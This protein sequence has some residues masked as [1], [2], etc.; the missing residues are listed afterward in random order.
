MGLLI[1]GFFAAK[2]LVLR[3]PLDLAPGPGYVQSPLSFKLY[4]WQTPDFF[5]CLRS[6]LPRIP[7][8]PS[9]SM[10]FRKHFKGAIYETHHPLMVFS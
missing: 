5:A 9:F 10:D 2:A 6:T 8:G 4:C 7:E 3:E 1:M